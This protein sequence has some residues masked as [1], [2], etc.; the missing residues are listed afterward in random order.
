MEQIKSYLENAK[1]A[2]KQVFG[3]LTVF[4]LLA[5]LILFQ[6]NKGV[7]WFLPFCVNMQT[8]VRKP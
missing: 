8:W 2:R 3:N 7:S 4:S 5:Q 1:F 6:T